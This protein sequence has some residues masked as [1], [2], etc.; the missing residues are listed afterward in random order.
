MNY[1][2]KTILN[3]IIKDT[4][5][6]VKTIEQYDENNSY[7]CE[8]IKNNIMNDSVFI[9][10]LYST[11]FFV[12]NGIYLYVNLNIINIEKFYNKYKCNFNVALNKELIC[13]IKMIEENLLKK[14]NINNKMPQYKIFEQLKNGNIKIFCDNNIIKTNNQFILKISGIW[15]NVQHYGLTYKFMAPND[16]YSVL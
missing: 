5:N 15:E 11:N 10:I 8:S 2:L 7:F 9:R 14:I 4:M 16:M 3:Y 6:I 1:N 12:M 13:K